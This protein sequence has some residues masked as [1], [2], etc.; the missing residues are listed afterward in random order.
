MCYIDFMAHTLLDKSFSV[1]VRGGVCWQSLFAAMQLRGHDCASLAVSLSASDEESISE[2]TV[3]AWLR[4]QREPTIGK[5]EKL[6]EIL[7]VEVAY[8]LKDRPR[9]KIS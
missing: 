3:E 5:L 1:G 6:A 8:L 7:K 2:R 9:K 4:G